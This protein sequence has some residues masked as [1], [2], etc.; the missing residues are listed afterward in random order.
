MDRVSNKKKKE[1]TIDSA[2]WM[3]LKGSMSE[4]S[5]SEKVTYCMIPYI[6]DIIE[7]TKLVVAK[8]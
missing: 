2:I 7:M 4:K 3:D 5:H 8:G 1:W 6:N